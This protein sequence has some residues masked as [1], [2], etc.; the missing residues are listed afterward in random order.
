ME[1]IYSPKSTSDIEEI[2]DYLVENFGHRVA[3]EKIDKIRETIE[4]LKTDP[5]FGRHIVDNIHKLKSG[6]SIIIY[7]VTDRFVEI[8]HVVDGRKD[9]VRTLGI[10]DD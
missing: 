10:D 9:W 4:I 3:N 5:F 6:M 8:H 2:Q 7:E 1:I